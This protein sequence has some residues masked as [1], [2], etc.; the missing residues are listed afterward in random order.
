[1]KILKIVA[2]VA[3]ALGL[4]QMAMANHDGGDGK[5]CDRKH[6]GMMKEA[7]TNKDGA[8]S[9][10]EFMTKHQ[11]HANKMFEKLDANK[12]GK[13]DEAEH[14]AGREKMREHHGDAPNHH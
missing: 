12:D 8:I 1:M 5:Q 14:K 9:R 13:I 11:E 10:D 6:Q 3:L 2:L 7:D 4:S